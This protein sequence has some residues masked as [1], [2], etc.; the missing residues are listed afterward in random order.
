ME[1]LGTWKLKAMIWLGKGGFRMMSDVEIAE[2]ENNDANKEF[3]CMLATDFIVS[4]TSLD[5]FYRPR[6]GEEGLAEQK[7]WK[8]T[9]RGFLIESFPCKIEDGV[10]YLDY[11]KK[12][13]EYSPTWIDEE[14]VLSLSGGLIK[15]K[16]V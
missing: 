16:K 5:I 2:M 3:K 6:E 8:V 10:L 12:G 9:E 13:A 15:I 11:L 4:E 14:G 1:I 7:G